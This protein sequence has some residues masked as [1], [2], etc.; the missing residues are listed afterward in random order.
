MLQRWETAARKLF[1]GSQWHYLHVSRVPLS[2][3]KRSPSSWDEGSVALSRDNCWRDFDA[4]STGSRNAVCRGSLGN[5]ITGSI[6]KQPF[7]RIVR[8]E[9]NLYPRNQTLFLILFL[10]ESAAVKESRW[11]QVQKY[12]THEICWLSSWLCPVTVSTG[13]VLLCLSH[14]A[15]IAVPGV[16]V[17]WQKAHFQIFSLGNVSRRTHGKSVTK[18]L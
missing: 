1:H 18:V 3:C 17:L 4:L 9:S 12:L 11:A 5:R 16:I 10:A 2:A 14:A 15:S 13:R 6:T 7:Q 8:T